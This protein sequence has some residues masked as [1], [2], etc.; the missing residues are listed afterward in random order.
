MKGTTLTII[1]LVA[2][3]SFQ[4]GFLFKTH[5]EHKYGPVPMITPSELVALMEEK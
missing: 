2:L 1:I 5:L 3:S 4:A